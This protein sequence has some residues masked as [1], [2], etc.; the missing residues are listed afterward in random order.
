MN[1][2]SGKQQISGVDVSR[3]L[4]VDVK[5]K[6]LF[7]SHVDVMFQLVPVFQTP[8]RYNLLLPDGM[9]FKSLKESPDRDCW[10]V[11]LFG[12]GGC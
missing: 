10:V 5:N 4:G 6:R 11:S 8:G 2:K 3:T 7:L 1:N 12:V 9:L